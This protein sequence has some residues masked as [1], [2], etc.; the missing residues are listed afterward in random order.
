MMSHQ[1]NLYQRR[2]LCSSRSFLFDVFVK[3]N[4]YFSAHMRWCWTA[5]NNLGTSLNS[6]TSALSANNLIDGWGI[7]RHRHPLPLF[8][9]L[10]S[11]SVQ[12][13]RGELYLSEHSP[14]F[15]LNYD[16]KK[17]SLSFLW[18]DMWLTALSASNFSWIWAI[19]F[20]TEKKLLLS[21]PTVLVMAFCVYC[22]CFKKE[23]EK[24]GMSLPFCLFVQELFIVKKNVRL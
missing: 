10:F 7:W 1:P 9:C 2:M 15:P 5:K 11:H 3:E 6:R 22:I 23:E 14:Q 20:S 4:K 13:N 19:S 21:L 12:H 16:L 8:C 18:G 24:N 17:K